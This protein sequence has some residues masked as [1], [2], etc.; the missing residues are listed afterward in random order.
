MVGQSQDQ[1]ILRTSKGAC[2]GMTT[3]RELRA[4]KQGRTCA[5]REA[6]G[7]ACPPLDGT[8]RFNADNPPRAAP[9]RAGS[10]MV[11]AHAAQIPSSS[12]ARNTNRAKL[13][14]GA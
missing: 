7:D 6:G 14:R 12:R 1:A 2:G 9:A 13:K 3:T 4:G 10:E 8:A 5:G 11:N